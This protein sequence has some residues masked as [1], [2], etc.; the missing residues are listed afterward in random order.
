MRYDESLPSQGGPAIGEDGKPTEDLGATHT[1]HSGSGSAETIGPYHLQQKLG[2][3]GMGEVWLA[4]QQE[5]VKRRVA[6]K[7]I[8]KGMDSKQVVARFEA[9]RQALALMDHPAVA[10]V[11]DAGTTPRGRPYF[12][13]EYVRG[14]PINEYCDRHRLN[15]GERLELFLQVC[16][17]V[18]HAHQKA[19][20]HRDLKPS[21]VLVTEQDGRRVPKIIDFGVA[22]A[23]AQKLTEKTLFTEL[24]VLIG[25]P[26]YMSPEQADLTGEDVDTRTDVYSL[27]VL[28]YELL[29]GALPFD[30][31]ELRRAGFD[32]IRRHIREKDPPRPS[33]RVSTLGDA[34]TD[35]ARKRSTDPNHL[36]GQLKGD[37]DWITMK[38]LEKDRTRRYSS[39]SALGED[40][41]R[42]LSS[43]PITAR[44]PSVTYQL[45]KFARRNRAVVLG[46]GVIL[47]VLLGAVVTSTLFALSEAKQ[48]READRARADLETV[49][50]FQ[51]GMLDDIDPQQMGLNFLNDLQEK[52]T[53][54]YTGRGAGSRDIDDALD[55]LRT[56]LRGVNAADL[57]LRMV[58]EDILDR[59]AQVIDS[60]FASQPLVAAR[61]LLSLAETYHTLGMYE[62]AEERSREAVEIREEHLGR[63]H[64]DT[65]TAI[66]TLGDDVWAQKRYEDAEVLWREA[67][68]GR[69]KV[70]GE[71]HEDTLNSMGN[72]GFIL[73]LQRRLDEA[74]PFLTQALEGK[75]RVLGDD[76]E[77]TLVSLANMAGLHSRRGEY[78]ETERYL[79]EALERSRRVRGKEDPA[80]LVLVNNLADCLDRQ[81]R[82]EEASSYYVEALEGFQRALG[83]KHPTTLVLR[84]NVAEVFKDQGKFAEAEAAYL[85]VLETRNEVLGEGHPDTLWTMK[86]LGDLKR[87][88]DD[89]EAARDFYVRALEISRRD[90]GEDH[91]RTLGLLNTLGG[92]H[93]SRREHEEAR[94]Y[95]EAA[96]AGNRRTR[97]PD[98][99]ATLDVAFSLAVLSDFA[100]E[101]GEAERAHAEILDTQRRVQEVY[102][103]R[104]FRS[105][106]ALSNVKEKLGKNEEVEALLREGLRASLEVNGEDDWQSLSFR[107][108]LGVLLKDL[109]RF[110]EAE[111]ELRKTLA[112][113]REVY[114]VDKKTTLNAM[115]NLADLLSKIGKLEKA[116]KL[117]RER[118]EITRQALPDDDGWIASSVTGL[119]YVL[120]KRGKYDEAEPLL[121]EALELRRKMKSPSWSVGSLSTR[122]GESLA[123]QGRFDAAE[124]L[125]LSGYRQIEDNFEDMPDNWKSL[126]VD[127]LKRIVALYEAWGKPDEAAKW[128]AKA[129]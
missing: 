4:E 23:T 113:R 116:E 54:A 120:N 119:A 16:E 22:K 84:N 95:Y 30:M 85:E 102:D 88:E 89:P 103:W 115:W 118:L 87:K 9:E 71:D 98:H 91:M 80:T 96:L 106:R 67:L 114:G 17:G 28:L 11:F 101:T 82:T 49:V 81:E 48:R 100:G 76:D 64:A 36:A 108:S 112:G 111:P 31:R 27:G 58:N 43:Q 86:K 21:N 25:T 33:A 122:L 26:E 2:E 78:E 121:R 24:G 5:P 41:Q 8:K 66:N 125:V 99:R 37:L 77:A 7:V 15:T 69:T 65:L 38:A 56:H 123:G 45:S 51:A 6:L 93:L 29:V 42:Y 68:A 50:E 62:Q 59:A 128:A 94:P 34:S 52:V 39:A 10:K 46:I 72:V 40:V 109:E 126:R 117:E 105:L 124:P 32:A 47:L 74:E 104:T 110:D 18:Q 129:D 73:T 55:S 107:G 14:V 13:M 44:P 35:S 90:L 57:A 19:I 83:N 127:A 75:R 20:I 97:G 12:A 79:R 3:G 60:E 63:E 70:L 1:E 61:L 53:E 92:F